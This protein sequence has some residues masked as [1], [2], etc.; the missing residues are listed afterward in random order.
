VHALAEFALGGGSG[1][2]SFGAEGDYFF[3]IALGDRQTTRHL[4]FLPLAGVHGVIQEF[5]GVF[6]GAILFRLRGGDGDGVQGM[7]FEQ[8]RPKLL[9]QRSGLEDVHRFDLPVDGH[10]GA[11]HLGMFRHRLLKL[12]EV[13]L[14][15]P[16]SC[17][18]GVVLREGVAGS[19]GAQGG[20]D[21]ADL[22]PDFALPFA[23]LDGDPA[24]F[25]EAP[26]LGDELT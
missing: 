8:F 15:L 2:I 4:A 3:G 6:R 22:V 21:L 26:G 13:G 12:F 10:Q 11:D 5:P 1:T 20:I 24:F 14:E 23:L 18:V 9:K 19:S 7:T 25:I 16:G 17:R